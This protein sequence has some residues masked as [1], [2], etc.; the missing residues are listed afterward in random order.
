MP[1]D[2]AVFI[3][4]HDFWKVESLH[5]VDAANTAIFAEVKLIATNI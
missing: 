2:D 3:S 5:T 4:Y 1:R